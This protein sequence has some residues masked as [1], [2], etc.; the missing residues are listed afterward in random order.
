MVLQ[1][2][3]KNSNKKLCKICNYEPCKWVLSEYT[4]RIVFELLKLQSTGGAL[5]AS[6]SLINDLFLMQYLYIIAATSI[7]AGLLLLKN[8]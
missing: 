2:L 5:Y 8:Q 6:I 3:Y 4:Q 1:N 7:T